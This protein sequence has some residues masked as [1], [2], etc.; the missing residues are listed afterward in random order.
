M[1]HP[2]VTARKSALASRMAPS[3][4]EWWDDA[5]CLGTDVA[6][7]SLTIT[8]KNGTEQERYDPRPT[9]KLCRTCPVRPSC[10]LEAVTQEMKEPNSVYLVWGG[11]NFGD[12]E[13]R[14]NG[15][16]G[17]PISPDDLPRLKAWAEERI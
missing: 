16:R 5:A 10:L 8:E 4:P 1:R 7:A 15:G 6:A 17:A 12:R 9:M 13:R 3:K 14:W 2:E 11:V